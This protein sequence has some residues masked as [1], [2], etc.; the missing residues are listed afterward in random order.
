[1]DHTL[2]TTGKL[3]RHAKK[4]EI[5]LAI[6]ECA[7]LAM[8]EAHDTGRIGNFSNFESR[9][10]MREVAVGLSVES[11]R[12]MVAGIPAFPWNRNR[13]AGQ[14]FIWDKHQIPYH[15]TPETTQ[16]YEAAKAKHTREK[17]DPWSIGPLD[18]VEAEAQ[19]DEGAGWR[20]YL[21]SLTDEERA[22]L[23][24]LEDG[25]EELEGWT[26]FDGTPVSGRD[27]IRLGL[28]L[29]DEKRGVE[30]RESP[31]VIRNR[32]LEEEKAMADPDTWSS[33][34][35]IKLG[36]ADAKRRAELEKGD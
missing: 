5:E 36:L 35:K 4:T 9:E 25:K 12:K 18:E 24:E 3:T 10:H 2:R 6:R 13:P 11:A 27:K 21:E 16:D 26:G 7:T 34:D 19:A 28:T 32:Q 29:Q 14:K 30:E 31:S 15:F 23:G 22:E 20:E 1:M 17:A 8:K 33:R